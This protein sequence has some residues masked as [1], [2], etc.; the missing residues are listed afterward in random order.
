VAQK[1]NHFDATAFDTVPF[2]N[3][4]YCGK[5]RLAAYPQP[6]NNLAVAVNFFPLE[7]IQQASSLAD[8]FQQSPAGMMIFFMGL[9]VFSEIPNPL[10]ENSNLYLR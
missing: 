1:E 3:P 7:V 2:H 6:G 8:Q 9:E 4:E 10:R 5:I